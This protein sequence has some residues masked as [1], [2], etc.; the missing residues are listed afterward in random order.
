MSQLQM[1]SL[2]SITNVPLGVCKSPARLVG[3]R[4]EGEMKEEG[5]RRKEEGRGRK[6]AER[7][8]YL[9]SQKF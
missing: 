7:R 9:S 4:K 3:R 8:R 1:V 6:E 5:G 2:L